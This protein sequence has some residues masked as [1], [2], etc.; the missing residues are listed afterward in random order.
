MLTMIARVCSKDALQQIQ[1]HGMEMFNDQA[2]ASRRT[3]WPMGPWLNP[4]WSGAEVDQ[5]VRYATLRQLECAAKQMN[6]RHVR[7]EIF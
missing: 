2:A 7:S 6:Q 3:R 1:Q 4:H 5:N